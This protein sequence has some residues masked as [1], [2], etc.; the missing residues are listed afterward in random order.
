MTAPVPVDEIDLALLELLRADARRPVAE[1]ARAV[2]LSP[3][4]VGRR[5]ARLERHGVLAGYTALIDETKLGRG[6]EAFAEVRVRGDLDV[7]A[8]LELAASMPEAQ[9]A[10][11]VAGDPDALIRLVVDDAEQLR[12]AINTLR[13][14]DGVLSTR[15]LLVIGSWRRA[16]TT[17]AQSRLEPEPQTIPLPRTTS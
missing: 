9:E 1:L 4:P 2:N 12:R 16:A 14:T 6:V 13:H 5:I 11:T 3:A 17:Q 10:F 8:V 15:T 7:T